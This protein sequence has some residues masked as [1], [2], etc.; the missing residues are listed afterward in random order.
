MQYLV[1]ILWLAYAARAVRES[2]RSHCGESNGGLADRR[3]AC[4]TSGMTPAE[5][6]TL[7]GKPTAIFARPGGAQWRYAAGGE[8][9]VVV[10]SGG[11]VAGCKQPQ[12]A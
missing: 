8:L 12:A 4:V 7:L 10:F 11:R 2:W 6:R 5:V 9:G 1:A 3:W